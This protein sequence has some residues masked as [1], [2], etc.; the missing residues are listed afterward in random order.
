MAITLCSIVTGTDGWFVYLLEYYG[1]LLPLSRRT[2]L[3]C[4]RHA[5]YQLVSVAGENQV[6]HLFLCLNARLKSQVD[7]LRY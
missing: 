1:R 3:V 4:A 7:S 2:N 6:V 5:D